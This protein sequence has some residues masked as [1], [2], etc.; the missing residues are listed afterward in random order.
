MAVPSQLDRREVVQTILR[1]RGDALV[2]SGLG[3]PTW[4]VASAGDSPLNFYLWGAMGGAAMLGFGLALAQPRRRVLVVTGDG[5]MLMGLGSFATIG[6]ERPRNLSIVVLDNERYGETGMQRSHTG[7]GVDLAA[8]AR[9]TAFPSVATVVTM[10]ELDAWL[11]I[12]HGTE[13]PVLTVVKVAA[14]QPPA[15]VPL[16]DGTQIKVRFREAVLGPEAE[17]TD[18]RRD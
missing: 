1:A 13:G 14:T 17:S 7:R 12:L 6:P 18:R 9:G 4:D 3:S 2:V 5:E 11:P 16:R 10:P 8:I 15:R